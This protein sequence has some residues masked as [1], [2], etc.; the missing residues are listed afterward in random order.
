MNILAGGIAIKC[1]FLYEA[2]FESLNKYQTDIT[3]EFFLSSSFDEPTFEKMDLI[4]E[5]DY[6]NLYQTE[7]GLYQIQ[8][9]NKNIV[10]SILYKNKEVFLFLK[11]KDFI[12][13]YLLSQYAFVHWIKE[14]TNSIFIHSSSISY[15]NNGVLLCAKSG[16][17]KS[18][19]RRLWEANGAICINDDKN[20]ISLIDDELYIM[21]NPWSG[22]HFC[23]NNLKVKLKALVFIY[24]N[25]ENVINKIGL[26]EG[27]MLLLQQIQLPS[28]KYKENWN[29][30]VDKLL[31]SCIIKYGCNMENEAFEVLSKYLKEVCFE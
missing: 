25:P 12:V 31:S 11:R 5:T 23:D 9:D 4:E 2:Q 26:K 17:G 19:H 6:Y 8:I 13:E 29:K 22:K 16:T 10:G 7:E 20:V 21:P 28:K 27:L 1:D 30:L 15:N 24:Q 18:T 3:P 14:N